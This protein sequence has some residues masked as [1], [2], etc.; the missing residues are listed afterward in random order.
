M[1]EEV[2]GAKLL[3]SIT[4]RTSSQYAEKLKKNYTKEFVEK[5]MQ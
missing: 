3:N 1:K 4:I 5:G 2:N